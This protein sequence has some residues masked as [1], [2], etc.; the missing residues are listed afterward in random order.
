MSKNPDG[1]IYTNDDY[2]NYA[3]LMLKTNTLYRDNDPSNNYPKSSKGQKWKRI[4]KT[5]W[6]NR[7]KYERSGVV[8]ILSDPNAL[9]ER[10]DLLLASKKSGSHGCRKRVSE[11]MQRIK[12]TRCFKFE[13]L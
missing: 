9:L 10:L 6:D 2:D 1:N 11:H 3:R 8:V 13:V 4:L 12:K 5:I 7:E